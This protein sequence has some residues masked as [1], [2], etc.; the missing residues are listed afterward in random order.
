MT[1]RPITHRRLPLLAAALALGLAAPTLA[2]AG[3]WAEP[4]AG[5]WAE[6]SAGT[7]AE[8]QEAFADLDDARG[9]QRLAQAAQEGDVRAMQAW[10][11]A[12]KH[13]PALFPGRLRADPAQAAHWFDRLARHCLA[14]RAR[15]DDGRPGPV[16]PACPG[17]P[18]AGGPQAGGTSS[19][20][21]AFL[22]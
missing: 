11:L 1:E 14:A 17:L 2:W 16:A 15:A 5:T 13:G 3:T 20:Q 10:A 6:P 4:S 22:R 9:L 8:A 12:L 18:L 19:R 21:G 7:W